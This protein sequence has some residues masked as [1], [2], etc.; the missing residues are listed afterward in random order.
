MDVR[1]TASIQVIPRFANKP[2]AALETCNLP[3]G[4]C[5][6]VIG[7]TA[8]AHDIE[9]RAEHNGY[10]ENLCSIQAANARWEAP[11]DCVLALKELLLH[12][13][14]RSPDVVTLFFTDVHLRSPMRREITWRAEGQGIVL[15]WPK[16]Q[17]PRFG[18][19]GTDAVCE[20]STG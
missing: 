2:T 14:L 12:S 9:S 15:I 19:E 18:A 6:K 13:P 3:L 17:Q 5:A 20:T 11:V 10:R 4:R 8:R 1:V 16:I 7:Q